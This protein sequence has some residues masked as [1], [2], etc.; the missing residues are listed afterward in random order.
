MQLA[1]MRETTAE[2]IDAA[3]SM[4]VDQIGAA[5]ETTTDEIAASRDMTESQIEATRQLTVRQIYFSRLQDDLRLN[6]AQAGVARALRNELLD[7]MAQFSSITLM[8]LLRSDGNSE[9]AMQKIL[10]EFDP[11]KSDELSR[12]V[13]VIKRFQ[14]ARFNSLTEQIVLLE[15]YEVEAVY[16]AYNSIQWTLKT[17]QEAESKASTNSADHIA[18]LCSFACHI[19]YS[20]V[21]N[22]ISALDDSIVAIEKERR[23]IREEI[24]NASN[25]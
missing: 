4:T 24:R 20:R 8:D 14:P 11:S 22:A 15:E 6:V 1:A 21:R 18:D 23:S 16:D 9:D 17:F 12:M 3:R 5:R 10:K 19:T 25:L 13:A 7:F 2:Q